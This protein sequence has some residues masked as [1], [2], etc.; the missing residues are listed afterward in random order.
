LEKRQSHVRSFL[1][2]LFI[3]TVGTLYLRLLLA[4]LFYQVSITFRTLTIDRFI[5]CNKITLRITVTTI[6]NPAFLGLP[7]DNIPFLALRTSDTDFLQDRFCVPTFRKVGT[8][9]KFTIS[10]HLIYHFMAAFLTSDSGRF[11]FYLVFFHS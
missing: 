8:R 5:P 7:F 2:I 3:I 1:C 10:S 4:F 11:I 6:K 9:K